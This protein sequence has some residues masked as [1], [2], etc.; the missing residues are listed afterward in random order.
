[1][2]LGKYFIVQSLEIWIN[3]SIQFSELSDSQGNFGQLQLE[4]LRK[5]WDDKVIWHMQ[6]ASFC[7]SESQ[8]SLFWLIIAPT[9]IKYHNYLKMYKQNER[10]RVAHKI[11]NWIYFFPRRKN[12]N[13]KMK[14]LQFSKTKLWQLSDFLF[15]NLNSAKKISSNK[16]F[17]RETTTVA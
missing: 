7:V 17:H 6:M 4:K 1:M 9:L 13:A 8:P 12:N 15:F 14:I 16:T 10:K 11:G 3:I 2:F 5:N